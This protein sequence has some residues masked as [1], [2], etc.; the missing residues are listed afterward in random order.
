[1]KKNTILIGLVLLWAVLSPRFG[2]SDEGPIITRL[3][4]T[5]ES[6]RHSRQVERIIPLRR[7]E[8]L[9]IADIART[10]SL[11]RKTGLYEKIHIE[12]KTVPGGV[13]IV[14]DLTPRRFIHT[15][16]FKHTFP[17]FESELRKA[18]RTREGMPYDEEKIQ[19]DVRLLE[20][21]LQ[22][23]GYFESDVRVSTKP[24]SKT[25]DVIVTFLITKG[26]TYRLG[27]IN[28]EGNRHLS[29]RYIKYLVRKNILFRYRK[30]KIEK[31]MEEILE[32]YRNR[33]FYEARVNADQIELDPR[34]RTVSVSLKINEGRRAKIVIRGDKHATKRKIKKQLTFSE[35]G[36]LDEFEVAESAFQ[37]S[38]MYKSGGYGDAQVNWSVEEKERRGKG[39]LVVI[40][41]QVNEGRQIHVG[42][43]EFPGAESF[44]PKK[45]KKQMV[46]GRRKYFGK[47][48]KLVDSVLKEDIAAI[49]TFYHDWGH[50]EVKVGPYRTKPRNEKGDKVTVIIPIEEGP[51]TVV[52][53]VRFEG[54]EFFQPEFVF[55][56]LTLVPG[57]PYNPSLLPG[58]KR[59]LL[60][61]YADYGFP[62]ARVSLKVERISTGDES[63][64]VA[65]TYSVVENKRVTVGE[66]VMRGNYRTKGRVLTRE[67]EL[68]PGEPF[69]YSE[70]LA[71]RRNLRGLPFLYSARLETLGLEENMDTAHIL[72]DV[73]ERPAKSLDFGVGYDSDLGSN[74]W[75]EWSDLNL[76]G[77]GKTGR[78]K[79]MGGDL[80]S[81]AEALYTDPR[82]LGTK[83]RADISGSWKYEKRETFNLTQVSGDF[84]LSKKLLKSL[85]GSLTARTEWNL[86]SGIVPQERE[87]IS[88]DENTIVGAGPMLVHDTRDDFIDPSRG[89]FNR[90]KT[91]YVREI[92]KKDEFIKAETTFSRFVPLTPRVVLALSVDIGHIKP[93]GDSQVPLQE[94]FFVGGN[95][96]VRG[97]SKDGLGPHGPDGDPT[98]GLEKIVTKVEL[99]FPIYS[100]LHGVLFTDSGQLVNTP[101][102]LRLDNQ[103]FTVGTGV[104]LMTPVGPIRLDWGYKLEPVW[105]ERR[106]RWHFSFGYPF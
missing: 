91:E 3:R 25:G 24:D 54:L 46:T 37:I 41:F 66:T 97:Y 104:R 106:Y 51:Q 83:T 11:L 43:V 30:E 100:V 10:I 103:Q 65:I 70:L 87:D 13:E 23:Q 57:A 85:T 32:A 16:K 89:W 99:R 88:I 29:D 2:A 75:M 9:A 101:E 86:L 52:R 22:E 96:S 44:K 81:G 28:I 62:Y 94:V 15:I 6:L 98:G 58:E 79:L 7:G 17:L 61:L 21:Y 50:A 69:S 18:A 59:K 48:S 33:G 19:L 105:W 20:A 8:H 90:A 64:Q 12:E 102:D 40:T 72:I 26:F 56:R 53:K 5:G 47:G 39:K 82:F 38:K 4:V 34:S 31:G 36:S 67:V 77:Y 27:D 42:E 84:S 68:Y 95:R 76:F 71:S 93:L 35:R 80:Q 73:T 92:I 14:V 1:M 45:L 63:R 60:L 78:L 55:D 49:E 74:I